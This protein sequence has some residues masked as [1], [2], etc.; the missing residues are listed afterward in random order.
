MADSANNV[1]TAVVADINLKQIICALHVKAVKE[2][3]KDKQYKIQNTAIDMNGDD[4]ESAKFY[5]AGTHMIAAIPADVKEGE[6]GSIPKA[7]ALKILQ[8]YAQW[9]SGPD[10]AKKITADKLIALED[11]KTGASEKT[12]EQTAKKKP[13][14]SSPAESIVIPIIPSFRQWLLTEEGEADGEPPTSGEAE[15]DKDQETDTEPPT[16]GEPEGDKDP[17]TE[18]SAPGYYITYKLKVE[19]QQEVT[20][21]EIFKKAAGDWIKSIGLVD[22]DWRA[23]AEGK[24][25][26]IGELADELDKIFG[27]IDPDELNSAYSTNLK[28]KF[29]KGDAISDVWDTK[30]ILQY[31]RKDLA[32]KDAKRIRDA[33]YAICTRVNKNDKSY[34]LYKP[35][36]IAD[37]ITSSI[38]GIVKIFK[39]RIKPDDVIL[40]NNYSDNKKENG[41]DK[42]YIDKDEGTVI[43][44]LSRHDYRTMIVEDGEPTEKE[45][46]TVEDVQKKLDEI[47]AEKLKDYTP[48]TKADTTENIISYLKSEGVDE[49]EL[50]SKLQDAA[51]S[52]LIQLKQPFYKDSDTTPSESI[53]VSYSLLSFLFEKT[54]ENNDKIIIENVKKCFMNFVMSYKA[55]DKDGKETKPDIS[56]MKDIIGYVSDKEPDTPTESYK[57][58]LGLFNLLYEDEDE[59]LLD[60]AKLADLLLEG[61]NVGKGV[62]FQIIDQ[63]GAKNLAAALPKMQMFIKANYKT[64]KGENKEDSLRYKALD[65]LEQFAKLTTEDDM[66]KFVDSKFEDGGKD[67][68]DSQLRTAF[69]RAMQ[70]DGIP[71]KEDDKD[72]DEEKKKIKITF[73]DSDPKTGEKLDKP[74]GD[75][76]EIDADTKPNSSEKVSDAQAKYNKQL[77]D[78]KKDGYEFKGWNPE[79]SEAADED[80]DIVAKYVED[81]KKDEKYTV[82]FQYAPDPEKPDDIKPIEVDGKEKQ[83]IAAG[84]KAVVPEA[85]KIDGYEFKEWDADGADFDNIDKDVMAIAKYEKAA[86]KEPEKDADTDKIAVYYAIPDMTGILNEEKEAEAKDNEVKTKHTD[87]DFYIVPMK[88]LKKKDDKS[89]EGK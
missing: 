57:D 88:G 1:Q 24:A 77:E 29:P 85:P 86:D 12:D 21:A 83:E 55:Y 10:T 7:E 79:T 36:V 82:M 73:Y 9:Y 5:G 47:A 6:T 56:F 50:F 60:E 74:L 80:T 54:L 70:I 46:N 30:T 84:E 67:S 58:T 51:H 15:G 16:S 26:T 87:Y 45:K 28:K 20:T 25:V 81:S 41:E 64:K 71:D 72:G 33:E 69:I 62:A 75:P 13:T 18:E 53:D 68:K 3:V 89:A 63:K 34:K 42:K 40:V 4:V 32:P 59:A 43:D 38:K 48:T 76:I 65:L 66:K 39:N 52:F 2:A 49:P 78:D 27:K 17:E 31:L 61:H 11:G 22:W 44:S 8:T 35:A 37:L 19:G 14:T 23:G